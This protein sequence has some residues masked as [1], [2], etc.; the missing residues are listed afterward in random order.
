M[1]MLPAIGNVA[2]TIPPG[3]I[4][5]LSLIVGALAAWSGLNGVIHIAQGASMFSGAKGR[6]QKREE[7]V[8]T[9][10]DG[11]WGLGIGASIIAI[12]AAI[13]NAAGV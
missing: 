11:A 8:E 9:C 12:I 3:V 7:A 4:N 10:K 5:V 2:L 1:V 13:R 6:P